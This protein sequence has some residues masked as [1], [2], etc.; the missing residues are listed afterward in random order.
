[1]LG[2]E[3]AV[4]WTIST[5]LHAGYW[6]VRPLPCEESVR[7]HAAALLLRRVVEP[8][9][10]CRPDWADRVRQLLSAGAAA[11]PGPLERAPERQPPEPAPAHLWLADR[12]DNTDMTPKLLRRGAPCGR[13][14]PPCSSVAR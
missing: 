4:P 11:S 1:V 7:T 14:Q 9:R 10:N 12:R 2:D 13:A 3:P 6:Q 8:F 5:D